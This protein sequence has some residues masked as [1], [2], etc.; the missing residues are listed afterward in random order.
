MAGVHRGPRAPGRIRRTSYR[1]TKF[2]L[3]DDRGRGDRDRRRVHRRDGAGHRPC[4]ARGRRTAVARSGRAVTRPRS[5][6][7]MTDGQRLLRQRRS[8]RAAAAATSADQIESARPGAERSC[9]N[10]WPRASPSADAQ[11][12]SSAGRPSRDVARQREAFCSGWTAP[13]S[14]VE[15]DASLRSTSRAMRSV[16]VELRDVSP[17]SLR[18]HAALKQS[19]STDAADR[20]LF[21]RRAWDVASRIPDGRRAAT[22]A[23]PMTV[24]VIDLDNFK[25]FNDSHGHTAGDALLQRFAAVATGASLR[26]NDVFARWGGEEF[27]IAHA[28]HHTCAGR[29]RS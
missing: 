20:R 13:R 25:A 3:I 6:S 17:P 8:R 9:R 15:V 7:S 28:R 11:M 22:D 19:A 14:S 26:R 10:G 18:A 29:S 5:S 27:L 21:N 4:R 24:A 23:V 1:S 16:Q 2:P 12:R